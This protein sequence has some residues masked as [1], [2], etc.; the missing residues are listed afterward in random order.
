MKRTQLGTFIVAALVAGTIA[1]PALARN[2]FSFSNSSASQYPVNYFASST[3][4][5]DQHK[6]DLAARVNQAL[7]QGRISPRQARSL[8]N[9]LDTFNKKEMRYLSRHTGALSALERLKLNASLDAIGLRLE[10]DI[11]ARKLFG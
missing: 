2:P 3:V 1:A 4:G 11:A 10:K 9:D 6:N 7:A 5:I 8:S